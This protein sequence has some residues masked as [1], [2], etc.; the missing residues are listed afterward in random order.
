MIF[1]VK[2]FF[3]FG[4]LLVT[5]SLPRKIFCL[6]FLDFL[7]SLERDE[8]IPI[9]RS[10]D[11]H[12]H[13]YTDSFASCDCR[14][15]IHLVYNRRRNLLPTHMGDLCFLNYT[16]IGLI[17]AVL[18]LQIRDRHEMSYL[19]GTLLKSLG[20]VFGTKWGLYE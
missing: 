16:D 2:I 3:L 4:H 14:N 7:S 19:S 10:R 8:K 18:Q 6:E 13:A 11:S 1:V 15:T 12:G 5:S 20:K 17:R 9:H